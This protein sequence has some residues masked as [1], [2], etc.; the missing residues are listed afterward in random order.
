MATQIFVNLPVKNLDRSVAFFTAL[1]Y[2][3]NPQ[4]TDK[5]ATCMIVSEDHIYVML[6]VEPFFQTFTPKS[7]A[8]ASQT[9]EVLLCLSCDSRDAV[10]AMV[11]KVLAAGGSAPNQPKDHGFMYQHGY[12]D[13]D[14]HLWEL[15]YMDPG[16]AN[17]AASDKATAP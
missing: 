17:N 11:K 15:V 16:F 1:G 5:N 6:L 4:F 7:I 2:T 3:F 14:G 12:Q 9:T 8:D 10:D 13:L